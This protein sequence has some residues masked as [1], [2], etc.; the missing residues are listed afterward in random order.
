M[1]EFFLLTLGAALDGGIVSWDALP[2]TIE[3]KLHPALPHTGCANSPRG[4]TLLD[5]PRTITGFVAMGPPGALLTWTRFCV[6]PRS[7]I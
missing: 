7:T 4:T 6:S 2:R 3:K 1:R 5:S